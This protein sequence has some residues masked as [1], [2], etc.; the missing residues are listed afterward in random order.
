MKL[1]ELRT[2]RGLSYEEIATA[3]ETSPENIERWEKG[4]EEPS[5][6]YV[7]KLAD[8]FQC[9]IRYLKGYP[10][11]D[12]QDIHS[13]PTQP[14]NTT[15]VYKEK[16]KRGCLVPC[17]IFLLIIAAI[18]LICVKCFNELNTNNNSN[19]NILERKATISDI[20]IT[21]EYDFPASIE[22]TI[23]PKYDI[24]DLVI[25]IEYYDSNNNLLK[26]QTKSIGDVN[27]G[28]PKTSSIEL[29][30]FTVTQAFKIKTCK[31]YVSAGTIS[32]VK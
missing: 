7:E 22:L 23:M 3:I 1:K 21:D 30:D 11:T 20:T 9:S 13:A 16:K 4:I 28:V 24:D 10:T 12:A 32:L 18:F 2:R 8:Y 27:A 17:L 15:V 31:Y 29:T 26:K 6:L 25:T 19:A 14:A 5:D